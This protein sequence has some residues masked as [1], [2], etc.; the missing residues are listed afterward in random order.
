MV[1]LPGSPLSCAQR[2]WSNICAPRRV[3]RN[4]S[5]AVMQFRCNPSVAKKGTDRQIHIHL[6]ATVSN[7]RIDN[8]FSKSP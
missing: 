7:T 2:A 3:Q 6:Q 1:Y 4:V 5:T 8:A